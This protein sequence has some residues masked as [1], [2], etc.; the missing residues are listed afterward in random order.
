[1]SA[2]GNATNPPTGGTERELAP[3]PGSA[4]LRCIWCIK[5]TQTNPCEH[6]GS[7]QVLNRTQPHRPHWSRWTIDTI[8]CKIC[9]RKAG[10]DQQLVRD[11]MC[12]PNEKGQL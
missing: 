7:D 5:D 8:K 12:R 1:M 2:N 3:P 10:Y 9:D 4:I 11:D 6:C